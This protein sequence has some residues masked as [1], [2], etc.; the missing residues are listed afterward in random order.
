[1]RYIVGIVGE[2]GAGK[3][4]FTIFLKAAAAP[5]SVSR[6]RFSDVL[7]E[8]LK[9]WGIDKTRANLQ[10]LAI[11]MDK[12]FGPG[13]VTHAAEA[14]LKRQKADIVIIEGIRWQTDVPMIKSMKNSFI[15]YVTAS[16][17]TRYARMKA[18]AEKVGEDKA[19]YE[20]FLK[21]EEAAT[22]TDIPKIGKTADFKIENDGDIDEFRKKVEE[23]YIK[24]KT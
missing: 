4:N 1:M 15:V 12:Q 7:V 20:Q 11:I 9:L 14:R 24:L 2:N 23:F 5:R 22:E 13:T 16:P 8:T 3:D 17:K 19:T 21:E 6:V 18:R 10:N